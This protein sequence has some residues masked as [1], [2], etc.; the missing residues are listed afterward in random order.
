M[1]VMFCCFVEYGFAL[2]GTRSRMFICES[3]WCNL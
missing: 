3:F 1:D 2:F